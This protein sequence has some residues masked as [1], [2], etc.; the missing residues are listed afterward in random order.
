[1]SQV[2]LK[3]HSGHKKGLRKEVDET[4]GKGRGK[5]KDSFRER[6]VRWYDKEPDGTPEE[7]EKAWNMAEKYLFKLIDYAEKDEP[8]PKEELEEA[9]RIFLFAKKGPRSRHFTISKTC[10]LTSADVLYFLTTTLPASNLSKLFDVEQNEITKI[11]RGETK[12][13]EWEYRFV[14][15]MK[16]MIRGRLYQTDAVKKR[17]YSISKVHSP[18]K[19]EILLYTTSERKAKQLRESIITK[20]EMTKLLKEKTLDILYPIERIDIV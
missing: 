2:V 19:T 10:K 12:Y 4:F 8:I 3:Y 18:N 1:M 14:K 5:F 15:R 6:K 9:K 17:I 13:W 7:L 16:G 11:R 20:L